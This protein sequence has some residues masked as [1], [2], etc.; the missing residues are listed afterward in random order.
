MHFNTSNITL[1]KNK[2]KPN[3]IRQFDIAVKYLYLGL[4]IIPIE[5]HAHD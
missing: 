1:Q 2:K 4:R 3:C 5:T